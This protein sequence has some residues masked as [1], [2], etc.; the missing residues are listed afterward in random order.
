MIR[1]QDRLSD[2]ALMERERYG[3]NAALFAFA[4]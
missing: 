3:L 1:T 2:P 4:Q